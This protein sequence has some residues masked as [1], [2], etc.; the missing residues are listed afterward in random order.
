MY[1]C[2]STFHIPTCFFSATHFILFKIGLPTFNIFY[3][4]SMNSECFESWKKLNMIAIS[5]WTSC[6]LYK[7]WTR[8]RISFEAVD[9]NRHLFHPYNT[10]TTDPPSHVPDV[11]E[12]LH[13]L[14]SNI[15]ISCDLAIILLKWILWFFW[16]VSN[17][18]HY[19]K[20]NLIFEG[21]KTMLTVHCTRIKTLIL[22]H[23][24]KNQVSGGPGVWYTKIR[25][26]AFNNSPQPCQGTMNQGGCYKALT[27]SKSILIA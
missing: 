9:T 19:Y 21:K 18:N 14:K 27:H 13:Y 20:N 26:F 17:H 8:K 1:T 11:V 24:N 15:M 12:Q 6:I 16:S 23:K 3:A 5:L 7:Q 2:L 25:I 22:L 10:H 4:I